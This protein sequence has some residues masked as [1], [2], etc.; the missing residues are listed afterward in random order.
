MVVTFLI[1]TNFGCY[2]SPDC[3]ETTSLKLLNYITKCVSD[4]IF[5][6]AA[7]QPTEISI[8][9]IIPHS[10]PE[11]IVIISGQNCNDGPY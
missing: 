10:V 9:E 1:F 4:V 8:S 2:L 7:L 6:F 3:F 11:A 5:V